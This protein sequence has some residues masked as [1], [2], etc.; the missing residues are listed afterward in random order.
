MIRK[1]LSK[2]Y[3]LT[4]KLAGSFLKYLDILSDI[5]F[6]KYVVIGL[7]TFLVFLK[8]LYYA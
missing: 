7:G 6:G 4:S 3:E 1:K 2:E 8:R 5:P